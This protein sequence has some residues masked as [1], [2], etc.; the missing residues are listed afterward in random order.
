MRRS[1]FLFG[2]VS[3]SIIF[4]GTEVFA[5][6][7]PLLQVDFTNRNWTEL[8][9][10]VSGKVLIDAGAAVLSPGTALATELFPYAPGQKIGVSVQ[11]KCLGV[12]PAQNGWDI[13]W[14][15]ITGYDA[16]RKEVSHQDILLIQGDK[17]W[18]TFDGTYDFND[19]VRYFRVHL[20]NSGRSGKVWYKNLKLSLKTVSEDLIGDSDFEGTLNADHWYFLKTGTDWDRLTTWTE[21]ARAVADSEIKV[22]GKNSLKL[23]GPAT[24]VSKPFPYHGE[25]LILTGW[26]RTQ[27][28]Q[29]GKTGWSGA[30]IQFVGLGTDGK[31]FCHHDPNISFKTTPWTYFQ[32]EYN[33]PAAVKNV[34][35]WIRMFEGA[36]GTAWFDQI[37]LERVPMGTV[38]PFDAKK[39][40][41]TI[42]AGHPGPVINHRVWAGIDT[43]VSIGWWLRDDI[44]QTMPY[45][46]KAGFELIRNHEIVNGLDIYPRDD[47][48]GRPVYQWNKFNSVFDLYVENGIIPVN[49][50]ETTPEALDKP[51]TRRPNYNNT[52]APRDMVKWG[53]FIE[54]VFEHVVE[55]YGKTEAEKWLWEVWNEPSFPSGYYTGTRGEYSD[56]AAQIYLAA[57]RVEKR[58]G[59]DLKLGL[60]SGSG[61]A[62]E[63]ILSRLQKMGLLDRVDHYSTHIYAGGSSSIRQVPEWTAGMRDYQKR[64][65]GMKKYLLGCTEWNCNSMAS[66]LFEKPWNTPFAV[67]FVKIM[68]DGGIDYSTYFGLSDHPELPHPPPIFIGDAMGMFTRN[69][70]PIPKPVY[71]AFVFMNELKG[72]KSLKLTSTNDPVD[73]LAVLMPNGAVRIVLASYDEDT[74]RQPYDTTVTV[75]FRGLPKQKYVCTRHWAA[76]DHHGNT[77]GK[78]IQMGKPPYENKAAKIAIAKEIDNIVIDPVTVEPDGSFKITLPSPGIRMIELKHQ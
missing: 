8:V 15:T 64:F 38:V 44:R 35:V 59:I 36:S 43:G 31:H 12:K 13:G 54:A 76:D 73:G 30:G 4:S 24:V 17:N 62:S 3:L 28:V 47:E 78:W 40:T 63:I 58:H 7:K 72:G 5:A 52:G 65:P 33:F 25:K 61:E 19:Q 9:R 18:Q 70:I 22:T 77:Q 21:P 51:G 32:A 71:N 23:T 60:A 48:K 37:R 53:K 69:E 57:G 6:Q 49:T 34:Q 67:K 41:V 1:F 46:K 29:C 10:P 74:S 55:R 68:M 11:A 26:I 45:L 27:D 14:A 20:S 75:K 16:A 50:I 66:A 42:D 56:I 39:A 2:I